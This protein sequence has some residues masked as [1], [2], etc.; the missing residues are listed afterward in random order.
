MVPVTPP[1]KDVMKI[2][3]LPEAGESVEQVAVMQV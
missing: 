1:A 3:K 2:T